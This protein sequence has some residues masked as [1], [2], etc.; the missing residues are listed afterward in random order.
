MDQNNTPTYGPYV[1]LDEELMRGWQTSI[2]K[3]SA[4]TEK[5]YFDILKISTYRN[6]PPDKKAMVE[7]QTGW[8]YHPTDKKLVRKKAA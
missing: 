3:R 4:T 5:A 1:L 6:A 8:Q 2:S 7:Q